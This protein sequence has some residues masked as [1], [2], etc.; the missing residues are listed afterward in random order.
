MRSPSKITRALWLALVLTTISTGAFAETNE[1]KHFVSSSFFMLGNFLPNPPSF[2]Q[3][4]Y[5]YRLTTRD[6]IIAEAITW[7]YDAPLG[8]PYGKS[9]GDSRYKF[10]GHARDIGV[11]F[12]Y[13]R[14]WW[15]GLYST[16]HITPFWQS[17]FDEQDRYIQSGFQ[18][19]LVARAGYHFSFW[20]KRI[21]IEPS[22]AVTSWP[23]NTNLP[24][25]FAKEE[26]KWPSYML[27]EPGLHFG[28]SF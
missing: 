17:Y 7:T 13:Q 20:K 9:Y 5:G 15:R 2:Y 6:T 11:G 27:L 16:V 23:I 21:F 18:L 10:K 19:F 28:V 8:I 24:E 4:N 14:Y 26:A 25:D 1:P 22:V 12:A 3:L